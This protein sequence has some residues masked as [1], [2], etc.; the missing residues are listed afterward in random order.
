MQDTE[1]II[2]TT[3]KL[4]DKI[5]EVVAP[6]LTTSDPPLVLETDVVAIVIAVK[7]TANSTGDIIR[8]GDV[9]LTLKES[10]DLSGNFSWQVCRIYNIFYV[11]CRQQGKECLIQKITSA[12]C[13]QQLKSFSCKGVNPLCCN[14]CTTEHLFCFHPDEFIQENITIKNAYVTCKSPCLIRAEFAA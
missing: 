11:S 8:A 4:I 1:D 7:D 10:E 14:N 12:G 9:T 5:G 3:L 2:E 13:E 6:T